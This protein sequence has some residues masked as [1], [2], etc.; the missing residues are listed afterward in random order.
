MFLEATESGDN[1]LWTVTLRD[2]VVRALAF[3][4]TRGVSFVFD[5]SAL[6]VVPAVFGVA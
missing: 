3:P 2:G 1:R 4:D 6:G 5:A